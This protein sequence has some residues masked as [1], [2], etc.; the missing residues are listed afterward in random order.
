M[1]RTSSP[2]L[3]PIREKVEAGERLSADDGL[4]M[5]RDDVPLPELG[6]LANVVR[7]RKNG[8]FAYYKEDPL[9][10]Y[11]VL[12]DLIG[13]THWKD[14]VFKRGKPTYCALGDGITDWAP[15]VKAL[16]QDGYDGYWTMEYEEPADVEIGMRK[17]ID[18]VLEAQRGT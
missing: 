6:E 7:E 12:R 13:Y 5:Y 2:I 9:A 1:L 8:N 3:Q 4:V 16:L 17:C 15:I 14:V 18:V 11:L 10:A